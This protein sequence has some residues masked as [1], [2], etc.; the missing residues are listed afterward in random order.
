MFNVSVIFCCAAINKKFSTLV[1]K[2]CLSMRSIEMRFDLSINL[3]SVTCKLLHFNI[4]KVLFFSGD[5][6]MTWVCRDD[7]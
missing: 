5:D 4:L 1:H 2:F 7:M 6:M 3:M